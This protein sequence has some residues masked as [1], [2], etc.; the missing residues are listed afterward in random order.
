MIMGRATWESIG[1]ALPGRQSIVMTRQAGFEAE[2]SDVVTSTAEALRAAGDVE[3]VMVIGGGNV[4]E[5]FLPECQRIYM[6]R[7]DSIIDGDTYFPDLDEDAWRVA[8]RESYP[9]SAERQYAFEFLTLNRLA[10][11][12]LTETD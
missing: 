8:D 7:V 3:E 4:Y 10:K 6:T 2:G 1:R 5:Q 12:R 9:A 11:L